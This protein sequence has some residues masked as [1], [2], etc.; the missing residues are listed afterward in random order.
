M[1]LDAYIGETVVLQ[2]LYLEDDG[3]ALAV[4]DPQVH[5]FRYT[6]EGERVSL[7]SEELRAV[8]VSDPGR[9]VH[10]YALPDSLVDGAVLYVEFRATHPDTG[11]LLV[12][13]EQINARSRGSSSSTGLNVRFVR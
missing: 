5:V 10:P 3:A 6:S 4:V 9:Y 11:N 13:R 2:V 12:S 7:L 1:S 8:G